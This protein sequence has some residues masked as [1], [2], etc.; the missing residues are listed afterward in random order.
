MAVSAD[1]AAGRGALFDLDGTLVN[2]EPR[3]LEVWAR[4]LEAHNRPY[5]REVLH[6][7]MGR[8]GPDVIAE[9]PSLFPGV[10][11]D[12]LLVELQRIGSATDLPPVEVLPES[13]KFVQSL[14]A[15]GVPIALVTSAGREW[16]QTALAMAGIAELFT[17][18]VT[19]GDVAEG[20]P[21]PEG[22][23]AG[24]GILG[25]PPERI[26]VFE[27]TPAGVEAG[28]RAGMGVVGVTTTH[29]RETLYGADLVVDHLT[30]VGWPPP[31]GT[32]R[33]KA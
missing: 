6:R 31:A 29:A 18:L 19:A 12:V 13:V 4:L 15:R 21:D 9:D 22:Y 2:S 26:T 16:A 25:V 23:L 33:A 1:G 24:A 20:K 7:F 10:S 8:R 28:R 17:G 14:H 27:D 3:S 32:G 11:W 5:D 30:E